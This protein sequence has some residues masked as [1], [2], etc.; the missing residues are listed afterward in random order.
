MPAPIYRSQLN[1]PLT[2]ADLDSNI[3][4][5]LDRANHTGQQPASTISDFSTA[6]QN[7]AVITALQ[8]CCTTLT[9]EIDQLQQD[10]FG[11]G[12]LST[13]LATYTQ[14]LQ[15]QINTLSAQ[16]STLNQGLSATNTNVTGLQQSFAT[17]NTFAQSLSNRL[18]LLKTPA[19]IIYVDAV[20]GN[21]SNTGF[22]SGTAI[23]TLDK[24]SEYIGTKIQASNGIEIKLANGTYD[25]TAFAGRIDGQSNRFVK[26]GETKYQHILYITGNTTDP[27]QVIINH[28][29]FDSRSPVGAATPNLKVAGGLHIAS[30]WA[31]IQGITFQFN[32]AKIPSGNKVGSATSIYCALQS[33]V[34]IDKC[35]FKPI[36]NSSSYWG[37]D[38][39]FNVTSAQFNTPGLTTTGVQIGAADN[40]SVVIKDI[41][42]DGNNANGFNCT[43]LVQ[44]LS[45]SSVTSDDG[46]I[47]LTNSPRFASI[48]EIGD[49]C[50]FF[51][52][53]RPSL[54]RFNL[55]FVGNFGTRTGQTTVHT[56][57]GG[58][59]SAIPTTE[60]NRTII[61]NPLYSAVLFPVEDAT[62]VIWP[63]TGNITKTTVWPI[64]LSGNL[65]NA[66][67]SFVDTR[68][69]PPTLSTTVNI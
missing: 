26:P 52:G 7:L 32:A 69:N 33:W 10:I 29:F 43:A 68:P 21:D 20:N 65:T 44:A 60:I 22:T 36:D 40:S 66:Y 15:N 67:Y 62:Y 54:S 2:C 50:T 19:A 17:L 34:Y 13:L 1:R 28:A 8:T 30:Q 4:A 38:S 58:S 23:R 25:G 27:S 64:T 9:A 49:R 24:A 55:R 57:Q 35:I 42:I 14:G 63:A 18:N 48:F 41:T 12:E 45:S 5:T 37:H 31:I 6:V 11:E 3:D 61:L 59:S 39:Y 46:T 56:S 47:T 51:V 16:Y 53:W